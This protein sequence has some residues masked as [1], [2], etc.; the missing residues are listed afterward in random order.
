MGV[1]ERP[2]MAPKYHIKYI[3]YHYLA[4]SS[5]VGFKLVDPDLIL[6]GYNQVDV[7]E[8]LNPFLSAIGPV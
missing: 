7:F 1:Q 5:P 6:V 2:K 3:K 8:P 4:I